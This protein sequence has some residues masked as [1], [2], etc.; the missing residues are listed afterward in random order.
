MGNPIVML[1]RNGVRRYLVWSTGADAP[2]TYGM[3]L[4]ELCRYIRDVY[5][6][7][8]LEGLRGRMA[9]V[10]ACGTSELHD[11]SAHDTIWFNRCGES[12]KDGGYPG[13]PQ[14]T[15]AQ[16]P[17]HPPGVRWTEDE[18]WDYFV[19]RYEAGEFDEDDVEQDDEEPGWCAEDREIFERESNAT[20]QSHAKG[21]DP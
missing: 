19:T 1:Q 8:G 18:I 6:S 11:R 12:F 10:H 2:V 4:S 15:A 7:N 9:R 14:L 20:Y 16:G 13:A 5:G 3:K 17:D 21:D